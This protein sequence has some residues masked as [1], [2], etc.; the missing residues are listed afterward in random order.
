[1]ET[2]ESAERCDD[3]DFV[4]YEPQ[5]SNHILDS[6]NNFRKAGCL[7][8][9]V[10]ST[11][12]KEFP[13]HRAV[14]ACSSPYFK[15]MFSAEMKETQEGRI[16]LDNVRAETLE[17][18]LEYAY[19]SKI[20]INSA[21]SQELL[22][23]A[24]LLQY[25]TIVQAAS[26]Y[27]ER[28]LHPDN[29]LGIKYVAEMHACTRLYERASAYALDRFPQVVKNEEFLQ[30]P[31]FEVVA[32]LSHE[33]INVRDEET[34]FDAAISWVKYEL[35]KRLPKLLVVLQCIRLPYLT[36]AF[37]CSILKNPLF[38]QQSSCFDVIQQAMHLQEYL[39][40]N[41]T[42]IYHVGHQPRWSTKTEVMV[43]VGGFD[44]NHTWVSD[45]HYYNPVNKKWGK[46]AP[47]PADISGYKV[48]ALDEDIYVTGG[49]SSRG[50][51]G[52]AFC[53]HS[54]QDQW[55]QVPG[56][57]IPRQY[58]GIVVLDSSIYVVGGEDGDGR[59]IG[60]VECYHPSMENWGWVPQ[61]PTAVGNPAVVSHSGKMYV[62]GGYC[63]GQLTYREMQCYNLDIDTWTVIN[64]VT[65]TTRHFPAL[66]LNDSIYLLSGAGKG[67]MQI[68]NP[69]T[70]TCG[71]NSEMCLLERH[72]FAVCV[73][74]GMIYVA[75]GMVNYKALGSV[76]MYD[77][78]TNT[79]KIVGCMPKPLRA[80]GCCASIR[81]YSGPP[82]IT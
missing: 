6:L 81:R 43:V 68:Y 45:V 44:A 15:A 34:V 73:M 22:E 36:P 47:F 55:N 76:E 29:C 72:L 38:K 49:K 27:L 25:K 59:C 54:A 3:T 61:L 13:C 42:N 24:D 41:E 35:K 65:I 39:Q 64:T 28:Q 9:T 62:I 46:F 75:G 56:L 51:T 80:H 30:L 48:V 11:G 14:L 32:Y 74:N 21:N 40:S 77:P 10:I 4:L 16:T 5:Y 71:R 67:G 58:H 31:L 1:M 12:G 53:Y 50:V 8:D 2:K 26:E 20:T 57:H 33:R 69:E 52:A 82:F 7:T 23:M 63:N 18:L 78:S 37:L 66:V 17:L 79:W 19:T 70:N 60:D